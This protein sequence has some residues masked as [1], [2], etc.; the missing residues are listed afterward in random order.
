M[1]NGESGVRSGM[2][3][4]R[5]INPPSVNETPMTMATIP[6]V[7]WLDDSDN[8]F[9]DAICFGGAVLGLGSQPHCL[10]LALPSPRP[11]PHFGHGNKTGSVEDIFSPGDEEDNWASR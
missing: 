10:H 8:S 11:V 5:N 1:E 6:N 4:S 7:R 3:V 2:E 9:G